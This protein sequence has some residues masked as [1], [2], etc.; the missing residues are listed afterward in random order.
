MKRQE[1]LNKL[2]GQVS[3]IQGDEAAAYGALYAGCNFFAGYPITP[4]SEVA[5]V[6]AGE[7]PKV[8]GYYI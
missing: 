6:M 4:A 3:F 5:E 1:Y 7:L 8:D 2:K